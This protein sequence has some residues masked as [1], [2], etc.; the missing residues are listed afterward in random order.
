MPRQKKIV[1]RFLV[2]IGA[3]L[4]ASCGGNE[5]S[6][7]VEQK[8][9]QPTSTKAPTPNQESL[10]TAEETQISI[11]ECEPPTTEIALGSP[12]NSEIVNDDQPPPERKFFCVYVPEGTSSITF[13]LTGTTS[14][15]NLYVGYPD[16]ET[17]QEGGFTFWYSEQE[18]A[19][20]E[21]I[22]VQPALKEFVEP[23]SYY[24]EV[25]AQDFR[26]SSPF[27]LSVYTP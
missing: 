27:T 14:D 13:E 2:A 8:I 7:T 19:A 6:I 17:V 5:T 22:I 23:G 11:G 16:L 18:G 1:F 10:S 4:L 15:L 24:I 3:L 9:T 25:T 21:I 26:G 12:V 20:D